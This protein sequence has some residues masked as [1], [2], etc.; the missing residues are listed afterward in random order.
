MS[1]AHPAPSGVNTEVPSIARVYDASLGGKDNFEVDRQLFARITD[2][3][4]EA[5]QLSQA[6]RRWLGR[7]VAHL[8]DAAG[9]D[10]F[11]DLGA[12]L[13]TAENTHE[14]AQRHRSD[15]TVVYVDNDP[16]VAAYGR[17][18]L[19]SNARTRL[20]TA[21]FLRPGEVRSTASEAGLDLHRPLALLQVGT[22]H[23]VG[24]EEDPWSVMRSYVDDLPSGSH[25]ALTHW[26]NPADGGAAEDLAVDIER[27]V[28]D[29]SPG[30]FRTTEQI[31]RFFDGLELLEPGLVEL[32]H[33]RP[34]EPVAAARSVVERLMI[35]GVGRKP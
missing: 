13:P 24:D 9:I 10:Q 4:P 26:W 33:W 3:A 25:V 6:N 29:L 1:R 14:I 18:I 31:A 32:D 27:R 28:T 11:L 7:V 20:A 19:A 15:A 21:D 2:V 30:R 34:A 23:H 12:G 22:L 8:A 17:A 5:P 35:G 16:A